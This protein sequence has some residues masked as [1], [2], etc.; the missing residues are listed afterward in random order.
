[1][2]PR[3]NAEK[4]GISV[5]SKEVSIGIYDDPFPD[6]KKEKEEMRGYERHI[7]MLLVLSVLI[8]VVFIWLFLMWIGG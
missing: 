2:N 8:W 7:T 6:Q 3:P 5:K 4:G 1:M